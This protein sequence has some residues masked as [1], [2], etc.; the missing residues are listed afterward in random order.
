MYTT[1]WDYDVAT[2]PVA[3]GA[4][5]HLTQGAAGQPNLDNGK[6]TYDRACAS[7]HGPQ[8]EGGHDGAPGL[9]ATRSAAI[10]IQ[11]VSEGRREM[12]SFRPSNL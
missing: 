6:A 7:C 5:W 11:T 2:P 9:R 3:S 4:A 1:T 8:G 12:P 10:I